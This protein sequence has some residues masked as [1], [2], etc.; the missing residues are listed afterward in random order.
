MTTVVI[1]AAVSVVPAIA[2]DLRTPPPGTQA[3]GREYGIV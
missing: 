1:V 3:D 2:T